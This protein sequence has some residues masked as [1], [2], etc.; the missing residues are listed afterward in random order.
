M[1]NLIIAYHGRRGQR[2]EGNQYTDRYCLCM[3]ILSCIGNLYFPY[4]FKGE[5]S[6]VSSM[7]DKSVE[8]LCWQIEAEHVN[9]AV[10]S[11]FSYTF[12]HI[13]NH[14]SA[15]EMINHCPGLGRHL[16]SPTHSLSHGNTKQRKI[17]LFFSKERW[18]GPQRHIITHTYKNVPKEGR[19]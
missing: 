9:L 7:H 3:R 5:T 19:G 16:I 2:L 10:R 13:R 17:T 1:T 15:L 14:V 18:K 4:Y 11:N 8:S 6:L 12:P